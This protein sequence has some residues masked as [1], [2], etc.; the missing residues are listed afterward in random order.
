M[1]H[2]GEVGFSLSDCSYEKACRYEFA[3]HNAGSNNIAYIGT[4]DEGWIVCSWVEDVENSLT[5]I[6]GDRLDPE[7][8]FGW[9]ICPQHAELFEPNVILLEAKNIFGHPSP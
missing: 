3:D 8:D 2:R 5:Y 1:G 4:T 7:Y 9:D 6:Y